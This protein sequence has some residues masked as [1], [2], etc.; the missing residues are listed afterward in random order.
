[1][2]RVVVKRWI[3]TQSADRVRLAA[4]LSVK[5][6]L[7]LVTMVEIWRYVGQLNKFPTLCNTFRSNLT[8]N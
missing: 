6:G 3:W 7:C 1:M 8:K 2:V 4:D 5:V